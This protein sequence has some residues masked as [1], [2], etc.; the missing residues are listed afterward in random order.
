MNPREPTLTELPRSDVGPSTGGIPGEEPVSTLRGAGVGVDGRRVGAVV[1]VL[2]LVA[3]GILSVILFVAGARKNAQ[4]TGLRTRGIPVDIRVIG[5]MGLLG[6]SGSNAAGYACKGTFSLDGHRYD[7]SIPG[8]VLHPPGTHV[9][10]V[11]V[12]SDP[13]LIST[14]SAVETDR[15]SGRVYLL[16]SILAA[17]FVV[18]LVALIMRWRHRPPH[19]AG[20]PDT[21]AL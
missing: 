16:P 8:N 4:L 3:V 9:Q 12:A 10:A 2:C 7:V 5:C 13:H 21:R 15:P 19:A 6:G 11:T 18:G 1:V 17:L 14:A 20:V